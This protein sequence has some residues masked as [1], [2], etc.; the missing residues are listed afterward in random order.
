MF[1]EEF[2]KLKE[3]KEDL[4]TMKG[5]LKGLKRTRYVAAYN[6]I[7][8]IAYKADSISKFRFGTM[9]SRMERARYCLSEPVLNSCVDY[10]EALIRMSD[11][12]LQVLTAKEFLAPKGYVS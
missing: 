9:V 6:E 11:E 1:T 12:Y 10:A 3:L 2:K 8:K 4:E 5:Y 7:M